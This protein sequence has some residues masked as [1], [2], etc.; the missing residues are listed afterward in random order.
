MPHKNLPSRILVCEATS[1]DKPQFIELFRDFMAEMGYDGDPELAWNL[2][3]LAHP[4]YRL[5]KL[6][7]DTT[8]VGFMDGLPLYQPIQPFKIGLVQYLYV[9]PAYRP[10][11]WKLMR[12]GLRYAKSVGINTVVTVED[13]RKSTYWQDHQF[14]IT[15]LLVERRF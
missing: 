4:D 7:I 1:T 9:K 11:A 14:A 8:I 2:L 3:P 6:V 15:R 5:W 12:T 10:Y 13:P